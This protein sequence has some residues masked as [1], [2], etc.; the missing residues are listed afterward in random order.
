MFNNALNMQIEDTKNFKGW[1]NGS[2]CQQKIS[3]S[4]SQICKLIEDGFEPSN[5]R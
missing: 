2:P 4:T 1:K 3:S 5:W